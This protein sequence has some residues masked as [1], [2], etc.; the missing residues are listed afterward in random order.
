M[1][2]SSRCDALLICL[3]IHSLFLP[4]SHGFTLPA[5]RCPSSYRRISASLHHQAPKS[6]LTQPS[7]RTISC[8]ANRDDTDS[9]IVSSPLSRVTG[10]LQSDYALTLS[11]IMTMAGAILG[12]LLDSYH[13]N[14]GVLKYD[15][16]FQL[17]LWS[18]SKEHPALVTCWW[19][20]LLFGLAGWLIGWLYVLYDAA[21]LS[22]TATETNYNPTNPT[23]P[24]ILVGISV[25][26]FQ[27]WLSGFL[28]AADVDRS[29]IFGIM[30][31]LAA[32][33]FVTLDK[34]LSGFI[35]NA[36]TAIGGP[37]IEV[38]LL[39]LAQNGGMGEYGYHYNDPGETGF[40][41]LWISPVYFLGGPA[42]GN[43][44]RG[45]WNALD[46]KVVAAVASN[47]APMDESPCN[48][49]G[50]SRQVPCPNCDG[51]GTYT[52]MGNR[53]T[54]CT[55]CRGRGFVICR[56]CFGRYGEDPYDINAIRELMSRMPD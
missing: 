41:P 31:M 13:S 9:S 35:A 51:V 26:T 21:F 24:K 4:N 36:S 16:P 17:Q 56:A 47:A 29:V 12:P 8:N 46:G 49:C 43:L 32:I 40:F 34:T 55:S 54:T 7:R 20:P 27:Y 5:T 2:E 45:V 44:A 18:V 19:V 15:S 10:M 14:F 28:F 42:V 37:L 25:F 52:A 1:K 30:S 23:V 3:I 53:V 38:A 39:S 50:D 22:T 48:V 6:R 11:A 33:G